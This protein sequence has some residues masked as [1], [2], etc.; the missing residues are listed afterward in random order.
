[1]LHKLIWYSFCGLLSWITITGFW[2]K[3][4]SP[5][6]YIVL[7]IGIYCPIRAT[8]EYIKIGAKKNKNNLQ[9]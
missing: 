3:S 2:E 6:K 4:D 5:L 7:I 1:M 9:D 8:I